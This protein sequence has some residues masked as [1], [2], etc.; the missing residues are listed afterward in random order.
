MTDD[1][2][3][4]AE[5]PSGFLPLDLAIT[6][7]ELQREVPG[8][9]YDLR[10]LQAIRR[11]IHAVDTYSHR[12]AVRHGI[13]SPQLICLLKILE[14]GELS[15]KALAREVYLS[16]STIVGIVDRLETKGLVRRE[17]SAKDRRLVQIKATEAG[18]RLGKDAPSP[19]QDAL[20]RAM[21]ELPAEE[22]AA[23]ASAFEHVVD[24]MENSDREAPAAAGDLT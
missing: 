19:L 15:L 11:I 9:R 13:T 16:P 10:I 12:M 4:P 22:K 2:H 6:P 20:A 14:A 18:E 5:M 21:N 17:R 8:E 7:N 24:L 23:L 1:I 3:T